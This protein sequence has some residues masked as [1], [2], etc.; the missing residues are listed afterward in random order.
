[1]EIDIEETAVFKGKLKPKPFVLNIDSKPSNAQIYLGETNLGFTPIRDY[2]ILTF[3]K[4]PL[5]IIRDEYFEVEE[6]IDVVPGGSIERVFN[7]KP[8]FGDLVILSDALDVKVYIDGKFVGNTPMEALP[9]IP[10]GKHVI[11]MR[12]EDYLPF[13]QVVELQPG[14]TNRFTLNPTAKY[15]YL[16][17]VSNVERARVTIGDKL[18]GFAPVNDFV[19]IKPGRYKAVVSDKNHFLW[20]KSI[21]LSPG[22]SIT[23]NAQMKSKLGSLNL[24]SNIDGAKVYL[25]ERYLGETP[26]KKPIQGIRTGEYKLV[27]TKKPYFDYERTIKLKPGRVNNHFAEMITTLGKL[28]VQA[29]VKNAQ[30]VLGKR[31]L[32]S[33][34]ADIFE[35]LQPGKFELL[36]TRDGFEPFKQPIEIVSNEVKTINVKL[37]RMKGGLVVNSKPT[38]GKV[39][40]DGKFSGV[41]PVKISKP[42]GNYT[43]IVKEKGYRDYKTRIRL[44]SGQPATINAEL[45]PKPYQ[46]Y[47]YS[48]Q[49]QA[50]VRIDGVLIGTTPVIGYRGSSFGVHRLEVSKDGFQKVI[51]RVRLQPGKRYKVNLDLKPIK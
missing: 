7:L 4:L 37:K 33:T 8:T 40:V 50:S 20:E 23:L 3:E 49:K 27:L 26:F 16:T 11:E 42:T 41:A 5:K 51:K 36:V 2:Q 31:Y 35:R 34:P 25:D 43:V 48:N 44:E 30:I 9:R 32:G 13:K 29:N 38:G 22:K 24:E 28:K 39:Y 18:V 19:R 21:V 6:K 14:T 47:I 46:L 17:V 1:M 10:M 15:A 45:S 12:H